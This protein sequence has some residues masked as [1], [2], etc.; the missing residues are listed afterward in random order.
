MR[1]LLAA[2]LAGS[3]APLS[4]AWT[5]PAYMD[6]VSPPRL[7]MGIGD[8]YL[9]KNGEKQEGY[10]NSLGSCLNKQTPE[11][12]K[13][14]PFPI[15]GGH[16]KFAFVNESETWTGDEFTVDMYFTDDP[17][18]ENKSFRHGGLKRMQTWSSFKTGMTCTVPMDMRIR[19]SKG[20][21]ADAIETW[22]GLNITFAL[23]V[24][25]H[26]GYKV[27]E[28]VDQVSLD[29]LLTGYEHM[30]IGD[31]KQCAYVT[32]TLDEGKSKRT[33][34]EEM[35]SRVNLDYFEGDADY[36][37]KDDDTISTSPDPDGSANQFGPVGYMFA[38]LLILYLSFSF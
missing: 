35:C 22:E 29:F 19:L 2:A 28:Q 5:I 37:G 16:I 11:N 8:A 1:A 13:R 32:L 15:T 27:F 33:T 30:L 25:A 12:V 14:T 6:L 10:T 26:R 34:E 38:S 31:A 9:I 4:S 21:D 20:E 17:W 18:G 24:K 3:L 23:Q 7:T 36:P